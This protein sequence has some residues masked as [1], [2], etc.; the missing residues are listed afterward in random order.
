MIFFSVRKKFTTCFYW[1]VAGMNLKMELGT[2]IR[3]ICQRHM[4]NEVEGNFYWN[5]NAS[6]CTTREYN[7]RK[8]YDIGSKTRILAS[9]SDSDGHTFI[10]ACPQIANKNVFNNFEKW[11]R[12]KLLEFRPGSVIAGYQ[13]KK[14]SLK[15]S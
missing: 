11:N 2:N 5:R 13:K 12:K 1:K 10:D 3:N 4:V 6:D 9:T 15:N 7:G 8:T 14:Q